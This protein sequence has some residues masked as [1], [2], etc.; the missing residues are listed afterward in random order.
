MSNYI[1]AL[2]GK[3]GGRVEV[4]ASKLQVNAGISE[5]LSMP[6]FNRKGRRRLS[7]LSSHEIAALLE[8]A[9]DY[10]YITTDFV[11]EIQKLLGKI[12]L[13]EKDK[14][15]SNMG[16]PLVTKEIALA[17]FMLSGMKHLKCVDIDFMLARNFRSLMTLGAGSEFFEILFEIE[18]AGPVRESRRTISIISAIQF[19]DLYVDELLEPP[20]LKTKKMISEF[21]Q[22][23]I[24]CGN[25]NWLD[26]NGESYLEAIRDMPFETFF[27]ELPK[28]QPVLDWFLATKP[29]FDKNQL[30]RGWKYL[31]K[32]SAIWHEQHPT[33]EF[34]DAFTSEAPSWDCILAAYVGQS[35]NAFLASSLYTIVPL[36]TLL[37][38]LDESQEMHHCVSSYVEYCLDGSTRIFSVRLTESNKR[39]A[40][41]ELSLSE[42]EWKLVQLKGKSNR[43]FIH[44]M[45]SPADPLASALQALVAWYNQHYQEGKK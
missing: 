4:S 42:G 43:E 11:H 21:E 29:S 18:K 19:L 32:K 30:K 5:L 8:F 3:N 14:N 20:R 6:G 12:E 27:D 9:P 36:N 40:T 45:N 17:A 2:Y 23:E 44:K 41:A 26:D 38:L 25:F 15:V 39:F 24:D 10:F 37:Q 22:H 7:L 31:E 16:R 35:G 1:D 33:R 28:L 13:R 34:Y